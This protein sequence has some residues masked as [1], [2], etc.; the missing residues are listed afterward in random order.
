M[1]LYRAIANICLVVLTASA[2]EDVAKEAKS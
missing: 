1:E 2:S